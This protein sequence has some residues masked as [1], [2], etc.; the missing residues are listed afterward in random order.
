MS[1]RFHTGRIALAVLCL[2]LVAGAFS[3]GGSATAAEDAPTR[4]ALDFTHGPLKTLQY[5]DG[6]GQ[7]K[8]YHYMLMTVTNGTSHPRSWYPWIRAITDTPDPAVT[9]GTKTYAAVGYSEALEAVQRRENNNEL[10]VPNRTMGRLDSGATVHIAA[11][12][13]PMDAQYD[14]IRIEVRG[15]VD[16]VAVYKVRVFGDDPTDEGVI[17]PRTM[18]VDGVYHEHN[19]ALRAELLAENDGAGPLPASKHQY[20]VVKEDRF[21]EMR[22]E[23]LGDEF[24]AEEDQIRFLGEGFKAAGLPKHI[25]TINADD[26][27]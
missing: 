14:H 19:E 25:R 5:D 4:W 10:Q 11:I 17:D 3:A 20:W 13:G 7:A 18:I 9:S 27:A 23:R 15:L 2:A 24:G 8:P 6:S 1:S 12:F 26:D 16:P 21:F 22:F